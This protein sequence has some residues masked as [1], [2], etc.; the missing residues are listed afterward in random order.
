[1]EV[2]V[3]PVC[4]NEPM[5]KNSPRGDEYCESMSQPSPR[6]AG[7]H[8]GDCGD[9]IFLIEACGQDALAVCARNAP[10][11]QTPSRRILRGPK[12]SEKTPAL[13]ATPP[14]ETR[15]WIV[16][17]TAQQNVTPLIQSTLQSARCGESIR[18]G[19]KNR[20]SCMRSGSN[21]LPAR[22]FIETNAGDF[23]DELTENYEASIAVDEPHT[24]RSI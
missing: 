3:K 10:A 1:M 8:G 4:P 22:V 7:I 6:T 16:H 15:R 18:A 2:P 17:R 21:T 11:V 20:V 5:G 12:L 23:F 14:S 9:V 13:P 24:R 19:G